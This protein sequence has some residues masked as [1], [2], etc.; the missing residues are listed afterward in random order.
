MRTRIF[1]TA[2]VITLLA[3]C[4]ELK[5]PLPTPT[6]PGIRVHPEQFADPTSAVFHGDVIRAAGWDMSE[7]RTCH[8]AD[9]NGGLVNQSC[10]TC[11]DNSA[12]PENCAT[13]H[14]STNPAPPRDISR[15]ES[16]SLPGV[17]AHQV[18]LTGSGEHSARIVPCGQCHTVPSMLY[19]AGHVDSDLPAEVAVQEGLAQADPTPPGGAPAYDYQSMTCS[20][21]YCHGNWNTH[22][23]ES[24]FPGLYTDSV[25]VGAIYAPVWTGGSAE[26]ECGT[27]HGL[28]PPGHLMYQLSECGACHDM[29][30]GANGE[31]ID[32]SKHINGKINVFG[33]ERSF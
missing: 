20:N 4:A 17:G 7:C 5:D 13:C 15:N 30:V 10:R 21:T 28:P 25:M 14:G 3:G 16:S 11:H 31:I 1:V 19:Q 6:A 23:N 22:V 33:E 32:P 12:G 27:C 26:A 2:G 24:R 9:Y 18:H 8:G 29:M